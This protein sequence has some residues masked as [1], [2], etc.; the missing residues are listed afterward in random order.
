MRKAT[1]LHAIQ[2]EINHITDRIEELKNGTIKTDLLFQKE[3]L[4]KFLESRL[5]DV[6]FEYNEEFDKFYRS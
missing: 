5:K 6:L 4:L 1:K 2:D 3:K